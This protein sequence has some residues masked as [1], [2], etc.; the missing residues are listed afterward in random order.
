MFEKALRLKLRF[1]FRGLCTIEDLWNLRLEDLDT[2]FKKLNAQAKILQDESLLSSK[3]EES[4]ILSLKIDIIKH[5]VAV[6]LKEREEREA[7]AERQSK[8]DKIL[9]VISE[10]QDE[11]LRNMSIEELKEMLI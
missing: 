7:A 11:D 10:K 3:S 4:E 2:L 6:R 8:R 1:E 5:I 9:H